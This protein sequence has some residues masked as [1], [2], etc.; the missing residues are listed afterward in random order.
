MTTPSTAATV[1]P[2]QE[3]GDDPA[4]IPIVFDPDRAEMTVVRKRYSTKF[5]PADMDGLNKRFIAILDTLRRQTDKGLKLGD[6]GKGYLQQ[7]KRVGTVAYN[8]VFPEGAQEYLR[9]L[10]AGEADRG[11]SL[12]LTL[13][14]DLKLFW[15]LL[16][17]PAKGERPA[18]LAKQEHF[19]GFRYP[20][21]RTY[22]DVGPES[23]RVRLRE[24][25]FSGRH[26]GLDG[27][28]REIEAIAKHIA[29]FC[30]GGRL[31]IIVQILD[32]EPHFCDL[33]EPSVDDLLTFFNSE[34]F[35]Y[36]ILHLACHCAEPRGAD[37]LESYLSM[38]INGKRL[39]LSI[40]ALDGYQ[41][42]GFEPYGPLVFLNACSSS[43]AHQPLQSFSMPVSFLG[44]QAGGVIAT[45][46]T[47]P[48]D[49]AEA[50]GA[51]FYT[52]LFHQNA[53]HLGR[54]NIGRALLETR[55]HFWE[56]YQNPLGLAYGLHAYAHHELVF[57][58]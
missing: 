12:T 53:L 55:N 40:E 45:A 6:A 32:D 1:K 39:D 23:D 20:L 21:G 19:W 44:N 11:L 16:Y 47:M 54:A 10:E 27:S 30:A 29:A 33:S 5:K 56:V 28:Q 13:P 15:E 31:K 7:L 8:K 46:C 48:D 2:R 22:W 51:Y 9:R 25:I 14:A 43:N 42:F 41:G 3:G 18:V 52:C 58:I 4:E 26:A 35:R 17:M 24:G 57:D 34:Q 38:T 37:A 36:G 50:F 49:F